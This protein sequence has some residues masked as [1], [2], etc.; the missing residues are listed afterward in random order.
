MGDRERTW[1]AEGQSTPWP[2]ALP[3]KLQQARILTW[4]YDAYFM[5]KPEVSSN[6]LVDHATNL[7]ANLTSDRESCNASSR[8]LIFVAHSLG[9]LVW[10]ATILLSR[11]NPETLFQS[12]FHA[13]KGVVFMGTLH[14]GAWMADWAKIP[15]TTFGFGKSTN[16]K[17]LN[18]LKRVNQ[19][20]E[21]IQGDFSAMKA[22]SKSGRNH[23]SSND[24]DRACLKDLYTTDPRD[25]KRR[26]EKVKGGPLKDSYRWTF[27]N[28]QFKQWRYEKQT[29]LLWVKGDPGQGK[30]LLLCGIIKEV[31][32]STSKYVA[33]SFFF[34][35]A[36]DTRLNHAAAVIRGL[37]YNLVDQQ[38]HLISHVRRQYDKSGRKGF[39]DVNAWEA[40]SKIFIDML[41]DSLLHSIYVIINAL[42][43]CTKDLDLL[44]DLVT[45][46]SSVYPHVKWIV[47]SRSWTVIGE[48]LEAATQKATLSLGL[49]EKSTAE[50]KKYKAE[51]R[52]AISQHLLSNAQGTFLWV[53]LVCEELA[54]AARWRNSSACSL[55]TAFPAGLEY[56]YYRMIE[57][58]RKSEDAGFCKRILGIVLLVYRPVTLAELPALVEIPEYIT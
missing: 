31:D 13:L 29:Q 55:L 6:G 53:A 44:L 2:R 41:E 24:A 40:L 46:K 32:Q 49:N 5:S 21:S 18:V 35:Q 26:I 38:P 47:S 30:K 15:V 51:T 58:V 27:D 4:G 43:E 34:C 52:D 19:L 23:D 45:Q 14:K 7:L 16:I 12:V 48:A 37:I 20:L 39:E 10:K 50:A 57:Q 54:N 28:D 25:D 3:Q 56:L 36:T 9:G 8:P 22:G 17:L 11:D 33:V 1:T 42:D